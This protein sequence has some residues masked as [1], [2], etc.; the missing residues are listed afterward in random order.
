[1]NWIK[2]L[3]NKLVSKTSVVSTLVL[4]EEETVA[5]ILTNILVTSGVGEEYIKE[6]VLA[7]FEEIY[8]GE[9]TEEAVNAGL[10][11]FIEANP[12]LGRGISKQQSAA[13]LK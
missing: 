3:W 11:A 5:E 13:R 10:S 12:G 7:P 9:A 6:H 8:D 2:T 1:M 4:A